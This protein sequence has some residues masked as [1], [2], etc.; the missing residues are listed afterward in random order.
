MVKKRA[1]SYKHHSTTS[2]MKAA[3]FPPHVLPSIQSIMDACLCLVSKGRPDSK[4]LLE[5]ASRH[6][7]ETVLALATRHDSNITSPT[8]ETVPAIVGK[9]SPTTSNHHVAKVVPFR[10]SI[11]ESGASGHVG[12]LIPIQ[13]GVHQHAIS[14]YPDKIGLGKAWIH[15][16][17]TKALT[18]MEG[19]VPALA[20]RHNSSNNSG[21]ISEFHVAKSSFGS[22]STKRSF[23]TNPG[24]ASG[25]S[26]GS[27]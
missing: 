25:A 7:D 5:N 20:M 9:H 11:H 17:K 6:V 23:Y 3:E 26:V 8:D 13:S 21:G 27:S 2:I 16:P 4:E 10:A 1:P 22:G 19:T 18:P 15:E 24:S 14:E 12:E